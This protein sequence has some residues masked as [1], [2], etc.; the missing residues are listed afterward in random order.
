MKQ[1]RLRWF[2]K[3]DKDEVSQLKSWLAAN[4]AGRYD[5]DILTYPTLQ[6]LCSYGDN[7]A[8]A[9]LPVQR[10]LVL[11]TYA[12]KPDN[13]PNVQAIRDLTKAATL[14]ASGHGIREIYFLGGDNGMGELAMRQVGFEKLGIPVYRLKVK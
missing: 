1:L 5:A 9:Y 7:G 14:I 10:A 6:V 12:P 11:E 2:N 4:P 8:E 3:D 13:P